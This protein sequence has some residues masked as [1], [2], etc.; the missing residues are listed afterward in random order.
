MSFPEGQT[1]WS[2]ISGCSYYGV[3][4]KQGPTVMEK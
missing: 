4:V 2:V 3:S 1:E